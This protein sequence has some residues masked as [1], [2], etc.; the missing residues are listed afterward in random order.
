MESFL[1]G[2]KFIDDEISAAI[3]SSYSYNKMSSFKGVEIES[4][5]FLNESAGAIPPK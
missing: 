5:L 2:Q 4:S 1:D 3:I